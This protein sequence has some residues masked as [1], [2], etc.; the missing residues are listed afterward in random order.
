L[1]ADNCLG[2]RFAYDASP[3]QASLQLR[4]TV[5]AYDIVM[6]YAAH[7]AS[8][9]RLMPKL[10]WL[11]SWKI[12]PTMDDM[13]ISLCDEIEDAVLSAVQSRKVYA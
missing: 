10:N 5:R 9:N 7:T 1:P 8:L 13:I 11:L 2:V 4:E 12:S 6:V 3:F